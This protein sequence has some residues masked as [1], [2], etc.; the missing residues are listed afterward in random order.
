ML[1]L[2]GT[3]REMSFHLLNAYQQMSMTSPIQAHMPHCVNALK[4]IMSMDDEA[5]DL[6][7]IRGIATQSHHRNEIRHTGRMLIACVCNCPI[8]SDS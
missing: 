4:P 6:I 1:I 7:S 5:Y 3:H 2:G 8:F